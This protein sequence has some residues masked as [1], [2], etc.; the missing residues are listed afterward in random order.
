MQMDIHARIY[1]PAA[2]VIIRKWSVQSKIFWFLFAIKLNFKRDILKLI[3]MHGYWIHL[4][5]FIFAF[6]IHVGLFIWCS[7]VK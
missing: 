2:Q 7:S 4:L 1:V 5:P 3:M 6:I